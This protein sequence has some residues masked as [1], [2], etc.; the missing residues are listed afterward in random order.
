MLFYYLFISESESPSGEKMKYVL[1]Y[2]S[3]YGHNKKLIDTL[4]EL[5]KQNGAEIQIFTTD[6][7]NPAAMPSA[8]LYVFSAPAEAFNLQMNMK[9]FLKS[10]SAMEGRNYGIMNTHAMRKSRLNKMEK[11]LSSKKMIKVAEMDFLI[12]KDMKSG[13]AFVEDWK[14]KLG[15]FAKKL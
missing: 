13:D 8:D 12:G 7:A 15:E 4:A 2:W 11:I 10:L 14:T 6:E 3:R 5:L 1:V 9:M